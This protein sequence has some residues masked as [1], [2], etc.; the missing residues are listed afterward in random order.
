MKKFAISGLLIGLSMVTTISHSNP[1][2]DDLIF[3]GG[4]SETYY[5]GTVNHHHVPG[6]VVV[7]PGDKKAG[8]D[9]RDNPFKNP[10]HFVTQESLSDQTLRYRTKN[11]DMKVAEDG[12]TINGD[13]HEWRRKNDSWGIFDRARK[14][15]ISVSSK[16][17]VT[18]QI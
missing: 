13:F 9:G 15:E 10:D 14:A 1:T 12:V 11:I 17:K 5:R 4:D 2:S 8:K 7:I 3:R 16:S 6:N 18:F